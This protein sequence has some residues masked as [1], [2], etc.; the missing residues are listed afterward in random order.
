MIKTV[1]DLEIFRLSHELA[2]DIYRITRKFPKE[3]R[4][5]LI[6]QVVRSSR[7]ITANISEGWGKRVYVNDFKRHL[8]FALGSLEETRTWLLFAKDCDYLK[9]E[10]YNCFCVKCQEIGAKIYK[11]LGTWRSF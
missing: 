2:M 6:D 10:D 8:I 5:S 3:E 7:S 1:F 4:Y 9:T 11:L